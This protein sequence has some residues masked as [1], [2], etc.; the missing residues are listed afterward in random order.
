MLSWIVDYNLHR[1]FEV[2]NKPGVYLQATKGSRPSIVARPGQDSYTSFSLAVV[3][4][5]KHKPNVTS[6]FCYVIIPTQSRPREEGSLFF[7]TVTGNEKEPMI[8]FCD[9]IMP[10]KDSIFTMWNKKKGQLIMALE[11]DKTLAIQ[12]RPRQHCDCGCITQDSSLE[13]KKVGGTLFTVSPSK[14]G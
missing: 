9:G 14:E 3:E 13:L 8:T 12:S 1:T 6:H 11:S 2:S 7:L 10:Q 5:P 4:A